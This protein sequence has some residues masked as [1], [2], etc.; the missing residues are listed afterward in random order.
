MTG[1]PLR[2]LISIMQVRLGFVSVGIPSALPA[3]AYL[4]SF[5]GIVRKHRW[6][7]RTHVARYRYRQGSVKIRSSRCPTCLG[8]I[9]PTLCEGALR[10]SRI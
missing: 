8:V 4:A 7:V 1:Y 6:D 9:S 2:L 3:R 10:A 5:G